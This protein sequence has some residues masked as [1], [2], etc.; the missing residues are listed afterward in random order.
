MAFASL[1][2]RVIAAYIGSLGEVA[3]LRDFARD[4][5]THVRRRAADRFDAVVLQA[6]DHFRCARRLG[7]RGGELVDDR[8]RRAGRRHHADPEI[9]L[10][11][12]QSHLGD[13]RHVRHQFG[14]MVAG[15]AEHAQPPGGDL[16]M[17]GRI[18]VELE[19]HDVGEQVGHCRRSA[20]IGDM[21]H[22]DADALQQQF[23]G[24]M[25]QRADAGRG[26]IELARILL[27]VGDEFLERL[28]RRSRIA[29][30]HLRHRGDDRDRHQV[31]FGVVR[32]LRLQRGVDGVVRRRQ[33]DRVA[34]R[35]RLGDGVG[36]DDTAGARLVFDHDRLAQIFSHLRG[37][38]A[39]DDVD[40]AA[41]RERQQQT[42]RPFRIFGEAGPGLRQNQRERSQRQRG[43]LESFHRPTPPG[44]WPPRFC[45]PRPSR[46]PASRLL[47]SPPCRPCRHIPSV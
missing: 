14:A 44:H 45:S 15:D 8:L 46:L 32:Q 6:L 27:G 22:L 11:A 1:A 21:R 16:R 47:K 19:L 31:F 36:G 18:G 29:D 20:A 4:Q 43:G 40:R 37:H 13:R 7:A 41:G 23:H 39:R 42:D 30:Q 9:A 38:H 2:P 3:P 33:Q 26:V 5:G 28:E 10:V 17:R 34:V 25:R 24:Q 12:G 35:R